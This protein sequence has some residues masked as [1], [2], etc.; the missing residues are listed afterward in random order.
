MALRRPPSTFS[1]DIVASDLAANSVTSSELAD[2]AV[3]AAAIASNAI[4]AAKLASTAL[5]SVEHVKP[6]IQPGTLQPAVAGKDLSG[7]ALGGSYVYGAA[8]TDGHKY[9]YTDIKGS[10]PIKDPRIGSHFGSQ[11]HTFRSIQLLEQETATHGQ[12]VYSVDGREWIRMCGANWG[13]GYKND[14]N[15]VRFEIHGSTGSPADHF[16]EITGYFNAVN[17]KQY[18]DSYVDQHLVSINGTANSSVTDLAVSSTGGPLVSRYVDGSSLF[19]LSFDSAPSLGINTVKFT[20][21]SGMYIAASGCELIVQDTTSAANRSKVQIPSQEVVSFGKKFTVGGSSA[22]THYNPF[23]GFT[24][25]T[26]ISSYIDEA[27]SLGMSKWKISSTWYKPFNGG[28]VVRWVDS[29]G[30]IKTSVTMMPPNAKSIA[31]SASPPNAFA[32]RTNA[33]DYATNNPMNSFETGTDLDVDRLSEVAKTF[34]MREF[35]NGSAN[36][37][38]SYKDASTL[39]NTPANVAYVM[40][41]GLTTLHSSLLSS[42]ANAIDWYLSNSSQAL[43]IT[44]IG[45]GI[46]LKRDDMTGVAG[47]NDGIYAQNLPYGTHIIKFVRGGSAHEAYLDGVTLS[48]TLV[49]TGFTGHI[50]GKYITFHQPKMPPI[51]EDAIILSDYMLMA[52]FVAQT[53]NNSKLISK[54]TRL[55][56][57]SRDHFHN[58]VSGAIDLKHAVYPAKDKG[59]TVRY[60]NLTNENGPSIPYFGD[61]KAVASIMSDSDASPTHTHRYDNST[62]NVTCVSTSGSVSGAVVSSFPASSSGAGY[63]ISSSKSDGVMGVHTFSHK[64]TP[65]GGTT[66]WL[67]YS[68]TQVATP[69]HTSSHYQTFE[70]PF[71]HELV[72]GDR[73]MEQ[74]NLVVT[75]DGKTW[76]EVTRDTSYIGNACVSTY[77]GVTSNSN[78]EIQVFDDWR[79]SPH[80]NKTYYNKDFAIGYNRVICLV[81]GHYTIN[82]RI[83][84]NTNNVN[85]AVIKLNGTTHVN[86]ATPPSSGG[87][88]VETRYDIY[89]KRG[90]YIQSNGYHMAYADYSHF[91]I[92]RQIKN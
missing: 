12:N 29:T 91:T 7:T 45:T 69:I 35:G 52:D 72:G 5:A 76:D 60:T 2:N 55:I 64:A 67:Y 66:D 81:D 57:S 88:T 10:K 58:T 78:S 86:G 4:T 42:G 48:T 3:D 27:T 84:T 43:Y 41:D 9:Y 51:P 40:D 74:T 38:A 17:W 90:D 22:S 37:H 50:G 39:Y 62:T 30:V 28:R 36:G 46:S 82:I 85:A 61:T 49:N 1:D 16:I 92:S 59:I 23:N 77:C 68:D 21:V 79:G 24:N 18:I 73:N 25:G 71:L 19:S 83:Y 6:H 63:Q 13:T 44:F 33:G 54:G 89:L 53:G 70:T 75:P 47:T 15:G 14:T 87:G 65:S 32:T 31:N 26:A 34:H 11:R 80:S 8:H 56:S 20:G